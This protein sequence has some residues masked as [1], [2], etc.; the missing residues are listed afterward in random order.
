MSDGRKRETRVVVLTVILAAS[1]LF[2]TIEAALFVMEE[3]CG[4]ALITEQGGKP[5]FEFMRV[6]DFSP[7]GAL[8][9][10]AAGDR[11]GLGQP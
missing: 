6:K 7:H 4:I 3:H 8:P 1:V 11:L 2:G 10:A 9:G 5:S